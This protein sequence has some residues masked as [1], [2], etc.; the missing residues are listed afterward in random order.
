[1]TRFSFRPD[2]LAAYQQLRSDTSAEPG[3]RLQAALGRLI[4]DT[5]AARGESAR[6][7]TLHGK[8]WALSVI[9]PADR[10]WMILWAEQPPDVIE[11]FYVGPPRGR[12]TFWR[13]LDIAEQVTA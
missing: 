1:M 11:V 7:E 6:W 4:E 8:V 3:K 13:G 5:A 9:D 2:A 12:D 10:T